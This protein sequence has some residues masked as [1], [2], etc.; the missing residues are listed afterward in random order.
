MIEGFD[1]P[2]GKFSNTL[3]NVALIDCH[4]VMIQFRTFYNAI[5][6][7][8]QDTNILLYTALMQGFP[9]IETLID[10][11]FDLCPYALQVEGVLK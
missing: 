3:G 6:E 10:P 8:L 1:A 5:I 2:N 11:L 4:S 9:E 7:D